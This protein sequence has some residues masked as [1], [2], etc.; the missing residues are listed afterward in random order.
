MFKR[1]G[2]QLAP[3]KTR[4][5]TELPPRSSR[6]NPEEVCMSFAVADMW[7]SVPKATFLL[8]TG[9]LAKVRQFTQAE[10]ALLVCR[11]ARALPSKAV[12]V[13]LDPAATEAQRIEAWQTARKGLAAGA[14][15]PDSY[16]LGLS[17]LVETLSTGRARAKGSRTPDGPIELIDPAEF[18][19]FRLRGVDAVSERTGE[20][21][22]HDLRISAQDLLKFR[23]S[24]EA[25]A[26]RP[27]AGDDAAAPADDRPRGR[28][29]YLG[30][31]EL[32]VAG[33]GDKFNRMSDSGVSRRFMDQCTTMEQ[34]GKSPPKL[35]NDRRRIEA[36]VKKIRE[37]RLSAAAD[38]TDRSGA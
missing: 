22:W 27:S 11:V 35:P 12:V 8:L 25:E 1:R 13:P 15:R 32:F 6:A 37:G 10:S 4:Y 2:R 21:V 28:L 20:I 18:T 36:Q 30:L 23:Q 16:S 7:L 26:S 29:G 14:G 5:R 31:L 38:R 3:D 34:A 9:D 24:V 19:R 17:I 33:L